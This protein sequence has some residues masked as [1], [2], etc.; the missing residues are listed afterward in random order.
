MTGEI[1]TVSHLSVV[2]TTDEGEMTQTTAEN[3]ATSSSPRGAAF[4]YN[5]FVLVIG[6]MGT[7]ANGL[8]LYALVASKQ[9]KKHEL[10]VS[11]N[12][13]DLYSCLFLV[14]TYGLRLCNIQLTGSL[15]YWLCMLLF[16]ENLLWCGVSG[17]FVN[18]MFISI[19]RYLKVV[20]SAWSKKKLR[21]WMTYAA[22]AVAWISG[23]VHIM[24]IMF[25]SSAVINGVCFGY[26]MWKDPGSAMGY[27]IFYFVFSYFIVVLVFIFCYGKILMAIRRQARVMASHNEA[28]SSTTQAQLNHLQTS[29]SKTMILVCAFYAIAWLP[30]AIYVLLISLNINLTFDDGGYFMTLA[31]LYICASL[32]RHRHQTLSAFGML[33]D[34]NKSVS[35]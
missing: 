33:S 2:M 17:S 28:G 30:D 3:G 15:G 22:I 8:V 9:H 5:S 21:K 11:Q 7:A 18:L 27:S 35:G 1:S 23:F 26:V 19:E 31:F 29:A 16:N 12:A 10:I 32:H 4:Y 25:E 14:I 6:I 34:E 20:H 13:L 24:P